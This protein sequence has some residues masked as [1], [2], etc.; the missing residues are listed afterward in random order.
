MENRFWRILLNGVAMFIV[1]LLLFLP[2]ASNAADVLKPQQSPLIQPEVKRSG[3]KEEN[4]DTENFELGF[5]VGLMSVEDFGA[6]AVYGLRLAYHV[7]DNVF[8]EAAYARTKTGKTSFE[9]LNNVNLLTDAQREL[10]YYNVS[11]GYNL[12]M[13]EV[14]FGHSRAFNSSLYII[15]GGGSTK[16]AGD[17]RFSMNY[18]IGYRFLALDWLAVHLDVRDHVFD[19]DLLGQAKTTHNLEFS[20]GETFFF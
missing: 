8:I 7:T 17:N 2:V 12:F 4:I 6:H 11:F 18:G 19:I 15:A 3:F 14:F 13:G 16:F 5:Y 1:G 20:I 10:T 9:R